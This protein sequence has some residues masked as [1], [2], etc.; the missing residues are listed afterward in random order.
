[1]TT[2]SAAMFIMFPVVRNILIWCCMRE[3]RSPGSPARDF[4]PWD[5]CYLLPMHGGTCGLCFWFMLFVSSDFRVVD[6]RSPVD[7]RQS[8]ELMFYRSGWLS[9]MNCCLNFSSAPS[10]LDVGLP[11]TFSSQY[12]TSTQ[13][14][15]SILDVDVANR[16][17]PSSHSAR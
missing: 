4:Q 16:S 17:T 15:E 13:S 5:G 2:W 6:S 10:S 8:D 3:P 1:M 12:T 7:S 14:I 11:L 9:T